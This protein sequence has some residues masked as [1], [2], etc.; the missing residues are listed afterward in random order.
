MTKL[1]TITNMCLA[2]PGFNATL[3]DTGDAGCL[4]AYRPL[5]QHRWQ[6]QVSRLDQMAFKEFLRDPRGIRSFSLL[7]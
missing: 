2:Q 7:S 5:P 1:V 6:V 4:C 3:R